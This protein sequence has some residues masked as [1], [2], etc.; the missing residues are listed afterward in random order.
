MSKASS[1]RGSASIEFALVLPIL[2][3]LTLAM[4][5]VGLLVRDDLVLTNAARAAAREAAVTSDDDRVRSAMEDAAASLRAE[6]IE[7]SIE[8][9]ERGHPATVRLRYPD[10]IVVP[11]VGWLFPSTVTL[12]GEAS[13][14][15][16]FE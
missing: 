12:Q 3:I 10:R 14:R 4:V 11:F 13:M 5:Q 9:S 8:R 7:L 1:E 2:L 15:Q 16:E 6:D